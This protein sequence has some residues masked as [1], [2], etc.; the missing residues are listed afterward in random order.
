V[1]T[2]EEARRSLAEEWESINP[3]SPEEIAAF[4]RTSSGMAA[5]L[6]AWHEG[7][8]R[9]GLTA[10]IVA[11]A[12]M[13]NARRVL[14]VGAGLGQDL[15]ALEGLDRMAVEPNDELRNRLINVH[16]IPAAVDISEID[17]E[18]DLI[19]CIDVLEHVPDPA[20]L[21]EAMVSL[22]APHGMLIERTSTDDAGTPLHLESLR[23]WSP[24][25]ILAGLGF[26]PR[27]LID[28]MAVWQ[29]VPGLKQI[30]PATVLLCAW[31]AL[32]VE[33]FECLNQLSWPVLTYRGDALI[34]RVRS[35]AV[36]QWLQETDED[37][38]LMI[39]DDI[40]FKREDAAKVVD[41]ARKTK[42]IA[43]GAYSV[44]DGGHLACRT[45]TPGE[46][47]RFGDDAEPMEI[48]WAATGFM[49]A[50]RDVIEA[51]ADTMPICETSGGMDFWPMFMPSILTG[52]DGRSVYLSEDY[53]FCERA[54]E[55]GFKVWMDPSVGLIHYGQA[56]YTIWNMK[57]AE[58]VER[59]S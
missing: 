26:T 46:R 32:S 44:K 49:A 18:F 15:L 13:I 38:F 19:T 34:S 17:G 39:D 16:G 7:S 33:T 45:L 54:R 5:D 58:L 56:K 35:R 30:A 41:L 9:R 57:K 21:V 4:Y 12:T 36:S 6:A 8:F 52:S 51:I 24:G 53:A 47:I 25:H 10:S 27:H 23:G 29:R 43:C 2:T 1:V 28:G 42:S 37:V 50:H 59:G 11:A 20:A 40:A 31:R 14:D 48:K 22:L 3:Q 55:L